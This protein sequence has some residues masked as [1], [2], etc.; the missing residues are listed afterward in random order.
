MKSLAAVTL[1]LALAGCAVPMW[2]PVGV[3]ADDCLD[4]RAVVGAGHGVGGVAGA[5]RGGLRPVAVRRMGA[6]VE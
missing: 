2:Q 1:C 5:G 6:S 3:R 4:E